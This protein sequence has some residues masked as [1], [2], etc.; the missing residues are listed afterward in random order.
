MCGPAETA[1]GIL[2]R[3]ASERIVAETGGTGKGQAKDQGQVVVVGNVRG[4]EL[5]GL[6]LDELDVF[7]GRDLLIAIRIGG[8]QVGPALIG[9]HKAADGE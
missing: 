6:G 1:R 2:R 3:A 4:E 5:I 9:I 8:F 7:V